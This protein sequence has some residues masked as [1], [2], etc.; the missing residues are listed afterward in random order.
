MN[1]TDPASASASASNS[2]SQMCYVN[3]DIL[4]NRINDFQNAYSN[5]DF[6]LLIN[7][8]FFIL[9][10]SYIILEK[11][12]QLSF[13]QLEYFFMLLKNISFY[14]FAVDLFYMFL[15]LI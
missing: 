7:I 5:I 10:Y 12:E 11:R 2:L 4:Y 8:I 14:V 6:V 3:C 1:Y 15:F 9:F 13:K